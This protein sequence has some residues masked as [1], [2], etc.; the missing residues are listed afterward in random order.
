M[1]MF[2]QHCFKPT[3][4]AIHGQ[5]RIGIHFNVGAISISKSETINHIERTAFAIAQAD[6]FNL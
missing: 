5:P 1:K 6:P 3:P 2:P 4:A